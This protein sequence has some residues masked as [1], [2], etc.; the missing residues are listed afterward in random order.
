M[1]YKAT[2]SALPAEYYSL[3]TSLG[4][5]QSLVDGLVLLL[6]GVQAVFVAQGIRD[7]LKH[8][9]ML[10]AK[11][12][13]P[14]AVT[15]VALLATKQNL[16]AT[17]ALAVQASLHHIPHGMLLQAWQA[18]VDYCWRQCLDGCPLH[19]CAAVAG[20]G[21]AIAC[22]TCQLRGAHCQARQVMS[23]VAPARPPSTCTG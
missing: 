10:L 19:W 16:A 7:R 17:H 13:S 8:S 20:L 4:V 1:L 11:L 14:T 2:L 22:C 9:K 5:R 23:C 18:W 21:A 12:V 15:P 6:A 3:R